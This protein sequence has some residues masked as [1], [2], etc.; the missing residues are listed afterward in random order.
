[1]ELTN[2][3]VESFL[4]LDQLNKLDAGVNTPIFELRKN[5][6][7][8]DESSFDSEVNEGE[9][10][11][12]ISIA[13]IFKNPGLLGECTSQVV[14]VKK[15]GIEESRYA[16]IF[17]Q[18]LYFNRK[19]CKVLRIHDCTKLKQNSKLEAQNKMLTIYTSTM[20]HELLTPL[21]CIK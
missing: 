4:G 2:S 11:T 21:R 16:Q 5:S 15:N 17:V 10:D 13:E 3:F 6:R 9:T 8:E 18:E 1:M 20:S 19:Q 14:K 12:L 7:S